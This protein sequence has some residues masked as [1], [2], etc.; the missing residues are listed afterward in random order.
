MEQGR[1]YLHGLYALEAVAHTHVD[2]FLIAFRK[3]SKACRHALKL[4]V[5][6][7]HLKQQTGTVVCWCRTISKDGSHVKVTEATSTLVLERMSIDLAGRT[8]EG[9]PTSAEISEYRTVVV[10]G[11]ASRDPVCALVC[12]WLL[13]DWAK[14]RSLVSRR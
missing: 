9:A 13:R 11:T 12:R 2:D 4:L 1:Y 8:L 6:T 5:H 3:A 14:R 7:L 10:V